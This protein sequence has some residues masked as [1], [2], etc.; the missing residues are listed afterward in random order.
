[1]YSVTV[2]ESRV[3]DQGVSKAMLPLKS[4]R[5]SFYDSSSFQWVVSNF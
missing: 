2:P 1:M 5:E 4:A 3:Q